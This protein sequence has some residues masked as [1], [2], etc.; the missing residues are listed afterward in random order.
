MMTSEIDGED[1]II[2]HLF[3]L[4]QSLEYEGVI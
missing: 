2:F 3:K 4:I 1:G